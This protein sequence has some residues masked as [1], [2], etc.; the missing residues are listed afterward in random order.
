MAALISVKI[1]GQVTD[2]IRRRWMSTANTRRV[3][4]L[5]GKYGVS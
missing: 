2:V 3:I 4:A 5:T 1:A